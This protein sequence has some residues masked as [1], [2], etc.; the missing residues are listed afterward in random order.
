MKLTDIEALASRPD[1]E[2]PLC[3]VTKHD[4]NGI[5]F[6]VDKTLKKPKHFLEK[7]KTSY[8]ISEYLY[9]E[10]IEKELFDVVKCSFEDDTLSY[11][12]Q[13]TLYKCLTRCFA[14]HRP[15]VLTPDVIWL[16]ICQTLAKHIYDNAEEYRERIVDHNDKMLIDVET[17]YAINDNRCDWPK[18][19]D[20]FYAEIDKKTK[21]GIANKMV[22]DFS[23]TGINERISSVATLMHGMESYFKYE[24]THYRCG[25]PYVT[26]K[27]N[28]SD[29]ERVLA[30][31]DILNDFGLNEWY[32]WLKPILKEFVRAASGKP[33]KTFWKNIVQSGRMRFPERGGCMPNFHY[34]NGWCVALLDHQDYDTD[35]PAYEKCFKD[36]SMKSE[37]TRVGFLYR[38]I[39]PSGKST[40]TP[41]ELWS[42]IIGVEE[43]KQ[44]FALTPKIGWFVRK[45]HEHEESISR[46]KEAINH[47]NLYL[48]IDEVPEILNEIDNIDS[49]TLRF[50]DEIKLPDWLFK[51]S[52]RMLNLY[53]KIDADYSAVIKKSFNKVSINDD[54]IFEDD[55]WL[56]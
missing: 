55:G 10:Q 6:L 44:T 51:K 45:S 39:W 14:E 8:I 17:P 28:Q 20:S 47:G 32:R 38:E 41:M 37:M 22:A 50:N 27:G 46:L 56:E 19:L 34:I 25:I 2:I 11:L 49:L 1:S 52:I 7:E 43:N 40:I 42:G 48:K 9:D 30:K 21:D 33:H 12:G 15:L 18:I 29:W 23:T 13:D 35:E 26:L 31:A 4:D 53:G 36:I 24:V 54:Y 5:T 16:I 3:K